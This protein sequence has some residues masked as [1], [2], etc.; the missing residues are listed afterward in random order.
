MDPFER[1][2][3]TRRTDTRIHGFFLIVLLPIAWKHPDI[4]AE[5]R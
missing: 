3:M 1:D 2:T 4:R 5:H